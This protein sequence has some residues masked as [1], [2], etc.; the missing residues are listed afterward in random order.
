MQQSLSSQKLRMRP[1]ECHGAK[2]TATNETNLFQRSE[3]ILHHGFGTWDVS[4][5][6]ILKKHVR[7]CVS[8][9]REKHARFNTFHE[10]QKSSQPRVFSKTICLYSPLR[11]YHHSPLLRL[12][13][14]PW[15][16]SSGRLDRC[17][18]EKTWG[19][20]LVLSTGHDAQEVST[21]VCFITGQT[22]ILGSPATRSP[23]NSWDLLRSNAKTL[24]SRL[25][26]WV[27]GPACE[28]LIVH[29]VNCCSSKL[30]KSM[31]REFYGRKSDSHSEIEF[32]YFNLSLSV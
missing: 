24:T 1:L 14:K 2:A 16:S 21:S 3:L 26:N 6:S 15:T 7:N 28:C 22:L 25:G 12:P 17:I 27:L 19:A 23:E 20:I 18:S 4:E 30:G 32:L 11:L 10:L 9:K 31:W 29:W 5:H 8:S 13:L